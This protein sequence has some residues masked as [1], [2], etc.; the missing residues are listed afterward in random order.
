MKIFNHVQIKVKDL[1]TSR[2]FYDAIMSVL[3]YPIV[4]DIKDVVVGYGTS[5][6]DMFEI[7]QFDAKS[8]LS[9]SVHLA[10]NASSR[11]N[12]DVFYRV[13]LENGANC[14]GKPGFRPEYEEGYYAAFIIDPDGHNI[15]AVYTE[16][17]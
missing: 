10:F 15:E 2:K 6:Y 8:L 11:K 9:K 7:R 13:A 1:K 17:K 4:L 14:N 3:E 12:V 5:V 16:K